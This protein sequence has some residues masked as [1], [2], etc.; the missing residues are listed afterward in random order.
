MTNPYPSKSALRIEADARRLLAQQAATAGV[1]HAA[2]KTFTEIFTA[3]HFPEGSPVAG[4]DLEDIENVLADLA[5]RREVSESDA[6]DTIRARE[7][8]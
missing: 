4:M 5:C 8:A 3:L 7:A 2:L 6:L 1:F